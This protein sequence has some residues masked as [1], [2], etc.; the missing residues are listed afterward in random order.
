[1]GPRR[2]SN[3][4][5]SCRGNHT[6]VRVSACLTSMERQIAWTS[7]GTSYRMKVGVTQDLMKITFTTNIQVLSAHSVAFL[8]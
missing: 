7:S 4:A 5:T 8:I 2:Y 6:A 3:N 1:M